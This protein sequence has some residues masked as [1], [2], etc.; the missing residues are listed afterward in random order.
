MYGLWR[1]WHAWHRASNE[2][3]WLA[4]SGAA[5]SLAAGAVV[6]GY[7]LAYNAGVW[8]LSRKHRRTLSARAGR[9]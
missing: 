4:A 1:A 5:G 3:S 7:Y 8:R 6:L 9:R 2:T